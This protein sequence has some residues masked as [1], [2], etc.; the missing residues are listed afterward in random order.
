VLLS[1]AIGAV[2]AA[3]R[4]KRPVVPLA[5]CLATLGV[6]VWLPLMP[7]ATGEMEL[8]AIDVGQGDALALRTP[9][10]RW[11]LIDAGRAWTGGDAG[12]RAVVPYV[13]QRGG[14]VAI[15]I[16]THPDDD[17][18][19]GAA[20]V[21]DAL[22]P[23]EFWDAAYV[24]PNA[25]YRGALAAAARR[26]VAW[27]RAQPGHTVAIDGLVLRVLA[28]DS[29]WTAAQDGPNDASTVV[30]AE[31]GETRMLLTGD[32]EVGEER[33]LVD[34]W[35]EE[36]NADVLKVGHHGSHTSSTPPFL[37]AVRARIA[38]VS[39]G[40]GNSYGHPHTDVLD[41]LA[42]RRMVV[43]RT[44]QLGSLVIS[45]DGHRIKVAGS[46]GAWVVPP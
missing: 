28:P 24:S 4:A 1:V 6:M 25:Q 23:R 26:N 22:R 10:G 29:A 39:V 45:T 8:H 2:L 36:L 40:A 34:R 44:D 42:M 20:S 5:S 14:E 31:F 18:V 37:D 41:A 15:F 11:V 43:L 12:R 38:V 27:R 30:L 13:R 3:C 46:D 19:G 21:I 35:G 33:W 9:K 7:R 16:L 32:A 17:H